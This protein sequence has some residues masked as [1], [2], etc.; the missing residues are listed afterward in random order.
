MN[1]FL[2]ECTGQLVMWMDD[3]TQGLHQDVD[4]LR[5]VQSESFVAHNVYV[6]SMLG[7]VFGNYRN[8]AVG[9]HEYCHFVLRYALADKAL[10]YLGD[11]A[12]CLLLI[13]FGSQ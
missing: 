7:H 1:R 3:E 9:T 11:A 5:R 6:W 4:G 10:Q 2:N 12:E 8:E 13:V